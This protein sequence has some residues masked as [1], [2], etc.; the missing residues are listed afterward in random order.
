MNGTAPKSVGWRRRFR[1]PK[2]SLHC[3]DLDGDGTKEISFA[4]EFGMYHTR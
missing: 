4:T 3:V 2:N 1:M